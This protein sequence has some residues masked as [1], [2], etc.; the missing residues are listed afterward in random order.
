MVCG[1]ERVR[2]PSSISPTAEKIDMAV[3][4]TQPD[5]C[6]MRVARRPAVAISPAVAAPRV[7]SRIEPPMRRT[8]ST[9]ASAISQK[10]KS[11]LV[12]PKSMVAPR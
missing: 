3:M 5:I 12:A 4:L 11:A 8:G 1:G 6:A 10:R 9:P 7:Q 2:M